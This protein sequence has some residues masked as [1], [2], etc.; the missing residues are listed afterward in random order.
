[1]Q[2]SLDPASEKTQG[3]LLRLRRQLHASP[4]PS[5][6]EKGGLSLA[7]SGSKAGLSPG[8]GG[9]IAETQ[10]SASPLSPGSKMESP[11]K[12]MGSSFGSFLASWK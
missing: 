12:G 5:G 9:T 6:S 1:M 8:G 10:D 3:D 7:V 11:A 4:T 2:L